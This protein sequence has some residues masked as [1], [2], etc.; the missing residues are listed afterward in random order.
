MAGTGISQH[1][2]QSRFGSQINDDQLR[3]LG[4]YEAMA[5]A[6]TPK[7]VFEDLATAKPVDGHKQEKC[8]EYVLRNFE[9]SGIGNW[10][11]V[12]K[13]DENYPKQLL[14]AAAV[15]QYFYYQGN[16]DLLKEPMVSVVGTRRAT[17][18]GLEKTG[19]LVKGLVKKGYTIVSGLAKGIDAKA[20]NSAIDNK[21]NTI[22]VI[23][24][25]LWKYYP[26]ENERLQ[27]VISE[28]FLVISQVPV[29]LYSKTNAQERKYGTFLL[30]RN[31]TMAALSEATI[32]MEGDTT[33][34]AYAQ[35]MQASKMK[36]EVL[37][38]IVLI[39]QN[40]IDK[41]KVREECF[42]MINEIGINLKQIEDVSDF[43][44]VL[45]KLQEFVRQ[46]K[47]KIDQ[48]REVIEQNTGKQSKLE[49]LLKRKEGVITV[50]DDQ[51][52]Y[53]ALKHKE[54][55]GTMFEAQE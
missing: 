47:E 43:H 12:F 9:R 28:K 31:I 54:L 3:R 46:S 14:D 22:A 49:A 20:H 19:E 7:K 37:K 50:K 52:V 32:V 23:G 29:N 48:A 36:Q 2:S 16:L 42:A 8:L 13:G 38:R 41:D 33:S 44:Q 27:R 35:A 45:S 10:G 17:P 25:P 53:T 40:V 55:S 26:K 30:A 6:S 5:L 11:V 34:G 15:L 24:N 18:Q 21:G 39:H 51:E 4:E 1:K